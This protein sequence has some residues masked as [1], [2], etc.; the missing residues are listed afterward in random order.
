MQL[1]KLSAV[2][3]PTMRLLKLSVPLS[4]LWA[5]WV[6]F[7]LAVVDSILANRLS[8]QLFPAVSKRIARRF[9]TNHFFTLA[10]FEFFRV[11]A[12]FGN[13]IQESYY[14]SLVIHWMLNKNKMIHRA[15]RVVFS[16][17]AFSLRWHYRP[18]H[19]TFNSFFKLTTDVRVLVNK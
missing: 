1:L 3:V 18:K 5:N 12:T 9:C 7:E 6:E 4:L 15:T 19:R 10:L 17:I 14:F 16:N 13:L 8:L 2:F 11:Q